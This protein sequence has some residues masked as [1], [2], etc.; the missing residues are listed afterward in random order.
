M[1]KP[2]HVQKNIDD[3]IYCEPVHF[4]DDI[5]ILPEESEDD[6]ESD[7]TEEI[8]EEDFYRFKDSLPSGNPWE[9]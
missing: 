4:P 9:E 2:K 7:T 3:E 6:L 1:K 8:T 5:E